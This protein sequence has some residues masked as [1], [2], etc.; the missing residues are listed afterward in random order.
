MPERVSDPVRMFRNWL[1]LVGIPNYIDPVRRPAPSSGVNMKIVHVIDYFQPKIGYQETFLAKE[2]AKLGHNVTVVT[3]DRYFPFPD[4]DATF[5]T[6]LGNRYVGTGKRTEEGITTW[7]LPSWEIPKSPLVLL[8]SLEQVLKTIHPD[9]VFC[10]GVYSL[11]SYM[12]A[13][14]K[15]RVGY[16]LVYDS[17]AAA[18]NTLLTDTFAKRWYFSLYQNVFAPVIKREMDTLFAVG[19]DE[20]K[21]LKDIL[22]LVDYDVPII[23]LGVDTQRFQFSKKEREEIRKE[24]G[25]SEKEIVVVCAGKMGK[26]KD[27]PVL[28]EAFNTLKNSNIRLLFIGRGEKGKQGRGETQ[29]LASL[30]EKIIHVPYVP[31]EKLPAY[32]SASDIGVWPGNFTMTILEAM[33]CSLPVILPKQSSTEYLKKSN[34][35]QWFTRGNSSELSDCIGFLASSPDIRKIYG[36][37]ARNYVEKELSWRIIA[38]KSI[39][40][41]P[42]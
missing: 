5:S 20:R 7:R 19:D 6:L 18:F 28:I 35:I 39:E 34:S 1:E 22:K 24:L 14:L 10:H 29:N 26:E 8:R 25:I 33:S 31:N 4:Y 2:H 16:T 17:H 27:I 37:N 12:T 36:R 32:F 21:F 13:R 42:H 41:I 23:R 9:V 38:I 11:T 30:R 3:S 40:I 15:N